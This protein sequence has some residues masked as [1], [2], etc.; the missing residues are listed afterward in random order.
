MT[1]LFQLSFKS[2]I[3]KRLDS[4]LSQQHRGIVINKNNGTPSFYPHFDHIADSLTIYTIKQNSICDH[5]TVIYAAISNHKLSL[6]K[7]PLPFL[8]FVITAKPPILIL[9]LGCQYQCYDN[10][11]ATTTEQIYNKHPYQV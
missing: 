7:I 2:A 5:S 3:L 6:F 11:T 1:S 9:P 8:S 10:M 4:S